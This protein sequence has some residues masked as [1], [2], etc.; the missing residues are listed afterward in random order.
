MITPSFVLSVPLKSCRYSSTNTCR[1]KRQHSNTASRLHRTCKCAIKRPSPPPDDKDDNEKNNATNSYFRR[2]WDDPE[3]PGE[4]IP[5]EPLN[6]NQETSIRSRLPRRIAEFVI[7]RASGVGRRAETI[8]SKLEE[9]NRGT[10]DMELEREYEDYV[11]ETDRNVRTSLFV[12][13][14]SQAEIEARQVGYG[15][16]A[17]FTL[18]VLFKTAASLVGFFV[19]FTFSF[20]AIFALSAGIFMVFIFFRF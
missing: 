8:M 9:E 5:T 13:E 17:I 3:S 11:Y 20:L 15:A 1:T 19:N 14:G 10:I 2:P 16:L 7:R 18:F 4:D 6:E 12:E